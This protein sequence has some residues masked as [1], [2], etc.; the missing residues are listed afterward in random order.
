MLVQKQVE[1]GQ[2]D[3]LD[4]NCP[5]YFLVLRLFAAMDVTDG[6]CVLPGFQPCNGGFGDQ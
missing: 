4:H 5:M 2:Y 1:S 6:V 3:A